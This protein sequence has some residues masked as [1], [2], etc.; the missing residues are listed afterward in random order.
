MKQS[1]QYQLYAYDYDTGTV[2]TVAE[3]KNISDYYVDLQNNILYY[4]VI[5][6]GLYQCRLDSSEQK[7]IY[8]AD[9]TIAVASLSFDG[10]YLYMG[11]GGIGSA[12]DAKRCNRQSSLCIGYRRKCMQQNSIC[13][14]I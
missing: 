11:N 9:A 6:E 8:K 3:G 5:G 2:Q 4:Y 13:R 7:L 14:A 12:T 10:R 1:F